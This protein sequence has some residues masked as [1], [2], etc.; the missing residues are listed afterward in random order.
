MTRHVFKE[1]KVKGTRR[2]TDASGKRRQETKTFSQT[3]NPFNKK[4]DG[5]IKTLEDIKRELTADRDF[6]LLEMSAKATGGA[7]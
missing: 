7:S 1:V 6:W 4:A 3:V 2:W 5:S